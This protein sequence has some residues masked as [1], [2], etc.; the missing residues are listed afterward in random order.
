VWGVGDTTILPPL[1]QAVRSGR[2]AWVGGGT[3]LTDTTHV[4]NVVEGLVLTAERGAAGE[5]YFVTDG[6]PVVF[7]E[8]ITELLATQGVEVPSRNVPP[9]VGRL[10]A[11]VGEGA[12][13]ALP[14]RGG[15]PLTRLAYWLSALECTIDISKARRDLGYEPVRTRTEGMDELRAAGAAA[16]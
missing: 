2:F 15:P 9:A 6:E 3:H 12:W 7:R 13:R 4:D 5:A 16:A 14:L 1:V 11:A 10:L 8:L